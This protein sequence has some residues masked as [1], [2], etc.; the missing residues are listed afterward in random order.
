MKNPKT[1]PEERRC[2]WSELSALLSVHI[3]DY[4]ANGS[5][6][7]SHCLGI[8]DMPDG[9]ALMLNPDYTHYYWLRYD[10]MESVISWDKWAAFR[11]ARDDKEKQEK[12]N[13]ETV[14]RLVAHS[15]MCAIRSM[16]IYR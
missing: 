8:Q 12:L 1:K 5:F 13:K 11:G 14:E 9:Y 4:E 10:G 6:N 15:G 3:H 16:D 2:L 7:A